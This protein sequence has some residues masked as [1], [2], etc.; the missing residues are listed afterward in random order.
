MLSWDEDFCLGLVD[1]GFF[2]I[3]FDN[4]DV[5][6]S[7]KIDV[8]GDLNVLETMMK[9]IG[10]EEADAPY[11][12]SDMADDAAGLL[13]ALGIDAAHVVGAS[14]GGMIAQTLAIEHRSRLLSLTSIMSTTGDLDVGQ[15]HPE[16]VP[17]LIEPAAR[18]RDANIEQS[19]KGSR[20]ISSPDHFDEERARVKAG[21]AYDYC[22]YPAGVGHQ[23]LAIYASGSRSDAL[24]GL[25]IN[26]LVIHGT[27]DPLVDPSG[28]ERTA[29]CLTGSELIMLEGMGHDLPPYFW[30]TVIEAIT[31]LA[32]RSAAA[33]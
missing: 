23:M 9:L 5:G 26:A 31:N 28:G 24:R 11:L 30:S 14:M 21:K 3:R 16:I 1:R 4:R 27:A 22:F 7:T 29:E 2:V 25:D 17:M 15:P 13:D 8:P 6:K 18:D 33:V 12:L 32:A 20:L 10:G 19:V